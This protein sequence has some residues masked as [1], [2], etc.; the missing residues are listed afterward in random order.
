VPASKVSLSGIV[1][2]AALTA[3]VVWL[4]AGCQGGGNQTFSCT[5][6]GMN[7]IGALGA[8]LAAAFPNT[9][10]APSMVDDCDSSGKASATLVVPGNVETV[11]RS[12]PST[13]ACERRHGDDLEVYL[14][15]DLDGQRS[16]VVIEFRSDDEVTVYARPL[17]PARH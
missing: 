13:W 8:N 10:Q 6:A 4:L 12:V 14:R 11:E 15:C 7:D 1:H 9:D 2:R 3:L 5:D 17:R 16:E